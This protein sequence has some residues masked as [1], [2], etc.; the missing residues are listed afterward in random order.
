M[1]SSLRQFIT[2]S[3]YDAQHQEARFPLTRAL[4]C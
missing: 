2:H 1:N 4:L 3:S